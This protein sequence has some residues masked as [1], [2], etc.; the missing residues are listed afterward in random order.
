MLVTLAGIVTF[1][2]FDIT[3]NAPYSIEVTP[4]GIIMLVRNGQN[5][6]DSYPMLVTPS[7]IAKIVSVLKMAYCIKT[8][9]SFEYK[10]PSIDL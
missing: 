4:F 8:F 5:A 1:V 7:G 2:R 9:P 6:N 3:Q 10:L